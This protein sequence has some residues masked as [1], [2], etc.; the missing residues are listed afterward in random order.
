MNG[1][2]RDESGGET[3]RFWE[4]HYRGHERRWSGRPNPVLVD[5]VGSL[6]PGDALDLG[7]G[8]GGDAIWLA[9]RGWRVT[10]VDVSAT[11]LDRAAADAATAGV[12]GRIDF[13]QQDLAIAIPS[14]AFDLVSA[15]YLHSP[16]EFPRVRVL[17]E[18]ASAVTTGGLLLIVDHASVR[19]GSWADPEETLTL[20]GLDPDGWRTERLEAHEREAIRPNGR[21]VTVTDN[22]VAL[23]RL[24][25]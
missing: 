10:A 18:A 23:R 6:R 20:L 8:E 16:I 13:Q 5:V 4:K 9:R 12:G 24:A 2:V 21:R 1:E 7:C 15:Q 17:R 25:R 3:E 19:P 14:G 11:A 22:V